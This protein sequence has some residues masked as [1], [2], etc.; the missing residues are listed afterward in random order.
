M[1][2]SILGKTIFVNVQFASKR[3]FFAFFKQKTGKN[4]AAPPFYGGA[5]KPIRPTARVLETKAVCSATFVA[6]DEEADE[7]NG[8]ASRN[9][10]TKAPTCA[11][12]LRLPGLPRLLQPDEVRRRPAR[13]SSNSRS[14]FVE[15][16]SIVA[17]GSVGT[18]KKLHLYMGDVDPTHAAYTNSCVRC[19]FGEPGLREQVFGFRE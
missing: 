12:R 1:G 6:A 16:R 4:A 7:E 2:R 13:E 8:S 14:N 18:V 11:G 5:A 9:E 10:M 15:S 3:T 19:V 17:I